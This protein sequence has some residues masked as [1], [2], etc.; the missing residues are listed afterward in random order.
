MSAFRGPGRESAVVHAPFAQ[1]QGAVVRSWWARA[2]ER[3]VAE[4]AYDERDL[5]RGR[6]LAR[7]AAVGAITL[8]SGSLYAAVSEGD[9]T[10][11]VTVALPVL[12]ESDIEALVEVV[13]SVSGWVGALML[14]DLPQDLVEAAE[15]LG[16][17][18]S[19]SGGE[20]ECDCTCDAWMQPCVHSL[21]LLTQT[22]WWADSDPFVLT[23]FRGVGRQGLLVRLDDLRASG[24][25][26]S[27]A[28]GGA[29]DGGAE[30]DG[31]GSVALAPW[32][33]E[34]ATVALEAAERAGVM[35]GEFAVDEVERTHS[36]PPSR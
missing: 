36:D 19:P 25:R 23:R 4:T 22:T 9:D 32:T 18:L 29:G 10:Y 24:G 2:M 8:D 28:G 15:E 7:K 20:F 30:S 33:E 31:D 11:T 34:D 1:R 5:R 6:T 26:G 3:A 12:T 27:G 21:A 35:L 14:G 16:V 17:E 13:A